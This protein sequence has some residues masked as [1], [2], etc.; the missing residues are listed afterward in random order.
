VSSEGGGGKGKQKGWI[1]GSW[2]HRKRRN[3]R[4]ILILRRNGDEENSR[5]MDEDL[6]YIPTS[7][8]SRKKLRQKDFRPRKT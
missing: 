3:K 7:E 6:K 1:R 5:T 8:R 4:R 2:G